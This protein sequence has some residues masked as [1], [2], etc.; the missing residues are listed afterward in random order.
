MPVTAKL[1]RRF[2][3]TFGDDI[4]NELVEWFNKVD[5]T[6]R[7]ELKELNEQ[8]FARFETKLQAVELG[9]GARFDALDH[10][11][12]TGLRA[13]ED[14]LGRVLSEQRSDLLKWMF[15]FWVGTT[16]SVLGTTIALLK[17]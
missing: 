1:S 4:A 7:S 8:N 10:R 14:R 5:A 9:V 17:L 11:F 6:Y 13:L 16:F 15:I 12:D 2:Y 3:E